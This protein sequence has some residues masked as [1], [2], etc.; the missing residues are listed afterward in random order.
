[1]NIRKDG[2]KKMQDMEVWDKIWK[3]FDFDAN[4][5]NTCE[6]LDSYYLIEE[7][8]GKRVGNKI[9]EVGCGSGLTSLILAKRYKLKPTF[10][11]ASAESIKICKKNAKRLSIE[12]VCVMA[13]AQELPFK[14]NEFDIVLSGGLI[15]HLTPE[16]KLK[17]MQEMYRVSKNLVI[18]IVPN[19]HNVPYRIG[20]FWRELL[21]KW[22]F[23]DENPLTK[24]ELR[25]LTEKSDAKIKV[26]GVRFIESLAW[27]FPHT[28]RFAKKLRG[29][30]SPL[31]NYGCELVLIMEKKGEQK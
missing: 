26:F 13:L 24:N 16:D 10:L 15:E 11:D 4:Y 29:R 9:L 18:V 22:A 25:S 30:R 23:G 14:D 7:Y 20:K 2:K 19:A 17:A 1:M 21:G 27:I 28:D 3:K 31:D 6:Q 12:A 8:F 5:R